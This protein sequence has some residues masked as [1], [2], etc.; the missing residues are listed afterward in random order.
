[1]MVVHKTVLSGSPADVSR[2]LGEA[3]RGMIPY[4]YDASTRLRE[5]AMELAGREN[6]NV[7][8]ATYDASSM[9]LQVT[10]SLGMPDD[11]ILLGRDKTGR[12]CQISWSS[13]KSINDETAI[14]EVADL[15]IAMLGIND[16]VDEQKG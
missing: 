5:L 6:V 8:I 7:T 15:V 3:C 4:E 16:G 14:R 13:W 2:K 10:L 11:P 1:M 12:N 9:E